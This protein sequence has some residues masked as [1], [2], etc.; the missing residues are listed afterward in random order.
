MAVRRAVRYGLLGVAALLVLILA[1][2][3]VFLAR[4][5][6]NSLKPRIEAAV[7]Q[8]TGRALTL[9][10]PI[11][12]TWSLS[13]TVALTDVAL[14][15]PPGFSQPQM[16]TLQSLDV[17]LAVLPL[18]HNRIEITRLVLQHPTILLETDAQGRSNWV[19]TPQP[20]TSAGV[21][22]AAAT[23][24]QAKPGEGDRIS[25]TALRIDDGTLSMRD[26][27]TGRAMTL[28][29]QHMTATATAADVPLNLAMN[30]SYNGTPF[31]LAGDVGS[32]LR[33]QDPNATTPWPVKLT[34]AAAGATASADGSFTKPLQGRG[35]TLSVT[36]AIPDLT[37][38]APL[39]PQAHL[40]PLHDVHVTAQLADHGGPVPYVEAANLK[41]GPADLTAYVGGLRLIS[42][43]IDAPAQNQ[44]IHIDAQ[45]TM[46]TTPMSLAATV[47]APGTL[48]AQQPSAPIPVDVIV[49]AGNA[50]LSV[51]GTVAHPETLSGANLA[52]TASIP[53][54]AAL[55]PIAHRKLPGL[56][57]VAF[58][59]TLTDGPGG[60]EHG[61]ALHE[62]K[63]TAAQGDLS[64]D[65]AI[66]NG[67][68]PSLTANLHANR[69]DADAIMAAAG[70]PVA[71]PPP[72]APPPAHQPPPPRPQATAPAAPPHA[73]TG[74]LFSDT[75]LPFGVLRA[76][77]GN[78]AVVI[79]DLR[80]GGLD[81]HAINVHA[82]LANGS[83]H[84]DPIAADLP[85]GKLSGTLAIDG[86][87]PAPPVALTLHAPGLA[88]APLLA[89]AGLPGYA[90]G[91]LEIYANLHSA[92]AS[93]HAI[94]AGL[95]GSLGLA[96]QGGTIDTA[97][98]NN[99][100]GSV[101]EKANVLGMLS[102]GGSS[103]LRCFALRADAHH[104][105][106]DLRTL[107]LNSALLTMD[108]GGSVNLGD[109]TLSL[110]LR[111][112]GRV[113]GTGLVV[114]M[115]V[116]GPI[117]DP[118]VKVNAIGTFEANAG[119]VA[120]GVIG[121]ATP[122]GLLGGVLG[123]DKLLGG[124]SVPSCDAALAVARGQAAPAA[125]AAPA[126]ARK[127]NSLGGVLQQLFR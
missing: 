63:L 43:T 119:T 48:I 24:P 114:P 75:P 70:K 80:T 108:G 118:A 18:L 8:A 107:L 54:L 126:P 57:Q 10:G 45:A 34:L 32:L 103:E 121:S 127:K 105:V 86:T 26:D 96:M 16:A 79:G 116:T 19:F 93:P 74:R 59:G 46:G 64:G 22:P 6:P 69:I 97:L 21:P 30:A 73:G 115:Q 27:R 50:N 60:F 76:A 7:E 84:V 5:D 99:L 56:T 89:A 90:S 109:E 62:M 67:P 17:Q 66:S 3:A 31:T 58:Q 68:P 72:P 124:S 40:P 2:G 92:G 9:K 117:R 55:S 82:V 91:R 38:L 37:A 25:V 15:N 94:A 95:N 4:F 111:P 53:D 23:K 81:Y 100:L 83:L 101:L 125:A 78:V 87:G 11:H 13:P 113:A 52:L 88:V 47:G 120:G 85:E 104:G 35:Y 14:A 71:P 12:L 112:Q 36:A 29:V 33:L 61:A 39:L 49:R 20:R 106:A 1:A 28:A 77:N 102:H 41:L 44:P 42:V 122:L 65:I 98:L 51:K 110:V 123:G